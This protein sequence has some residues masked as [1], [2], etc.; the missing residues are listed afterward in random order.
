MVATKITANTS[1]LKRRGSRVGGNRNRET[2]LARLFALR[3]S[4]YL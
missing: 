4:P 3:F 2:F 1:G